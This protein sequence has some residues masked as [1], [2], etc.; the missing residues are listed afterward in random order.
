MFAAQLAA[1]SFPKPEDPGSNLKKYLLLI[2]CRKDENKLKRGGNGPFK[3]HIWAL[4]TFQHYLVLLVLTYG[5]KFTVLS[6]MC[7]KLFHNIVN[8]SMIIDEDRKYHVQ[9]IF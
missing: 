4:Q 3:K 1:R 8:R 6:N 5:W 2:V 9:V 7:K